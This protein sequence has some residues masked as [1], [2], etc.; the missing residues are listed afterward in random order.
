MEVLTKVETLIFNQKLNYPLLQLI[1]NK[2]VQINTACHIK[3]FNEDSCDII[4]A[5]GQYRITGSDLRVKEY[6][7]SFMRIESSG[8]DKIE[9]LGMGDKVE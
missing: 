4:T 8:I 2:V 7:D 9:I 3:E 6:G 1:K 5:G